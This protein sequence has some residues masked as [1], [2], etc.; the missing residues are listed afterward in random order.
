MQRNCAIDC[1]KGLAILCITLLHFEAGIIPQN[2]NVWIGLFMITAFYFASGWISG[3]KGSN[4]AP[5]ELFF[6]RVRQLGIPYLWFSLA[7]LLFDLIWCIC[8][9]MGYNIFFRDIYKTLVLRGI[10]TLW[11]LPVLLFGEWL[12]CF[13]KSK[14]HCFV[15]GAGLFLLSFAA[16]YFYYK[17]LP[18][19]GNSDLMKLLEAPVRPVVYSLMAWPVILFGFGGGK[20][21]YPRVEN[22]KQIYSFCIGI[23]L[24]AISYLIVQF[25]ISLYFISTWVINVFSALGFLLVFSAFPKNPVSDFFAYW[26]KNSL[27]LMCIHFSI[28]QE[29]MMTIDKRFLH[30]A[31]FTGCRTLVYFV[32][33]VAITWLL[34][35]LFNNKLKFML[36]K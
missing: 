7:I 32:I 36:G 30:H 22:C 9:F 11:F 23:A 5:K 27:I 26:G 31:S 6:K 14:K 1:L 4:T 8:G 2:L 17:F 34:V 21:L 13:V 29:I 12:F 15:W 35:P 10:G 25:N 3:I 18:M 33:T 24:L 16:S 28:L 19:R 20:Y